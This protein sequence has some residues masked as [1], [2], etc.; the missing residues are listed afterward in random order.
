MKVHIFARKARATR[1]ARPPKT[2]K[3]IHAKTMQKIRHRQ[4]KIRT[5]TNYQKQNKQRKR[6]E[7]H[8][9]SRKILI[10]ARKMKVARKS[11]VTRNAPPPNTLHT[12]EH[13]IKKK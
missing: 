13:K 1:N 10:F 4:E 2:R 12:H 11:R 8:A 3:N 5:N 7:N 9:C 6:S